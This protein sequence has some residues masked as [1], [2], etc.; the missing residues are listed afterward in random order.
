MHFFV[1]L[2]LLTNAL[3]IIVMMYSP[4]KPL[5]TSVAKLVVREEIENFAAATFGA[6][7]R[8]EAACAEHRGTE[9]IVSGKGQT[10]HRT[11]IIEGVEVT[12]QT[13]F[14]YRALI[15]NHC[16]PLNPNCYDVQTL[17]LSGTNVVRPRI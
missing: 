8:L 2:S 4:V 15:E 9:G 12:G 5:D 16:S 6:Q 1:S 3:L 7:I 11:E 13:Q 17:G 10:E 14:T